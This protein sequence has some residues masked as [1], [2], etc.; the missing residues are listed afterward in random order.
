M[1]K[2]DEQ[3]KIQRRCRIKL[4][5]CLSTFA[6]RRYN[7]KKSSDRHRQSR[8]KCAVN[9][10]DQ[11]S[12]DASSPSPDPRPAAP[13]DNELTDSSARWQELD[14][15][16]KAILGIEA[17]TENL[18]ASVESLQLQMDASLKR[19][20]TI[21]EKSYA[22]RA[23]IAQWERAK[24]RVHYVLPRM[25]DFIHRAI[26]ALGA[27]ERKRLGELY[28][29]HIQP[30]IPFPEMNEVMKQLEDLQKDRQVL[31]GL[32]KAVYQESKAIAAEVQRAVSTL[33]N[34]AKSQRNKL[35]NTSKSRRV[36]C[37]ATWRCS[38]AC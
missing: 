10:A 7:G 28:K 19:T 14:A 32:G 33:Q 13:G 37:A 2:V 24:N 27:P 4:S 11:P 30:Q 35:A 3:K 6:D 38:G 23:D 12:P 36:C 26:W 16:W 18:R 34:N 31:S 17:A 15:R 29:E 1:A 8:G 20:L 22:L 21:E 5:A 25:K 9:P